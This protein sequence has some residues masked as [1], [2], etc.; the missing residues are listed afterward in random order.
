MAFV[1]APPLEDATNQ[2]RSLR[3]ARLDSYCMEGGDPVKAA[4]PVHAAIPS[5][6]E[7]A[8]ASSALDSI[9][10]HGSPSSRPSDAPDAS[11]AKRL[12]SS[13]PRNAYD[14]SDDELPPSPA[15]QVVTRRRRVQAGGSSRATSARGDLLRSRV[16]PAHGHA[17]KSSHGP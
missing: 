9:F 15:R 13:R 12:R 3:Q 16:A 6:P 7:R 17:R 8:P 2:P 10:A 11:I 14:S 4:G 5:T 1:L